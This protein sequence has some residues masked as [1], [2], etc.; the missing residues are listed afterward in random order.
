MRKFFDAV[1]PCPKKY[2]PVELNTF[3]EEGKTLDARIA[4]MPGLNKVEPSIYLAVVE[5]IAD[6]DTKRKTGAETRATTFIA[7]VATLIPLMT[8]A[9]GSTDK[10]VCSEGW[11]CLTWTAVFVLAV[12]YF[13]T[14][15][16]WALRSLAVANYHV[17]SVEDIVGVR[18]QQQ[19]ISQEL[20][21]QTLLASRRNRDT[22]NQKLTFIKVAQC[23]FFNGLLVLGLLLMYDPIS[24]F[25]TL[26]FVQSVVQGGAA[27]LWNWITVVCVG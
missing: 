14:A 1:W 17:I 19:D 3:A 6:D 12:V 26:A 22:I 18:E 25:G 10:S 23:R 27:R 24:R 20:I 5:R 11:G 16:Y 13:V 2:S 9:L 15:A 21:R 4:T 7:A 8:W